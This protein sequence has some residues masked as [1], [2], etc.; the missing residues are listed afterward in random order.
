MRPV[1]Q[2]V[3]QHAT[4]HST[5]AEP[6]G[7][8]SSLHPQDVY[9]QIALFFFLPLPCSLCRFLPSTSVNVCVCV[10]VCVRVRVYGTVITF[11]IFR[12]SA[13][14]S[15][16]TLMRYHLSQ[17]VIGTMVSVHKY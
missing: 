13:I 17:E 3:G 10:C 1:I 7:E 14:S 8:V 2:V 12:F 6:A 9:E 15:V 5:S 4:I 16:I 11:I